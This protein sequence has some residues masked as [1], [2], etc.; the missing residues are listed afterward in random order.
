MLCYVVIHPTPRVS[1]MYGL[2]SHIP[3]LG[4]AVTNL[5]HDRCPSAHAVGVDV[6]DTRCDRVSYNPLT[7]S[8]HNG[9]VEAVWVGHEI[10][11]SDLSAVEPYNSNAYNTGLIMGGVGYQGF[12]H[13]SAGRWIDGRET[14]IL[15]INFF[16]HQICRYEGT[17]GDNCPSNCLFPNKFICQIFVDLIFD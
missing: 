5:F 14:W 9:E 10:T 2:C 7:H 13:P 11:K 15:T 4:S 3:Q 1:I 6:Y 8:R 17:Q 12:W 16:H